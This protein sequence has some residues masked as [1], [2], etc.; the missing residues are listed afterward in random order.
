MC[1]VSLLG[2]QSNMQVQ[3]PSLGRGEKEISLSDIR[4]ISES[5]MYEIN[6][7]FEKH[8]LKSILLDCHIENRSKIGFVICT[9]KL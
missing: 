9:C 6:Q 7:I 1:R 8:L 5:S 4:L 3:D 2:M